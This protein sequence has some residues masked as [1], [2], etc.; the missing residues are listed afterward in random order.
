MNIYFAGAICGGRNDAGLYNQVIT[1][2]KQYG[3]VLTD[4]VGNQD[5]TAEGES[6]NTVTPKQVFD[7]DMEFMER[8]DV[9]IAE[10]TTPSLGVGYEI[11][12]AVELGKKILC[13]YNQENMS[14]DLSRIIKGNPYLTVKYYKN[15]RELYGFID[16]FLKTVKWVNLIT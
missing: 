12:K 14:R 1:Y 11:A 4:H 9:L 13:L 5:L 10:V 7:R 6:E 8:T 15:L 2:L 16:K 3:D